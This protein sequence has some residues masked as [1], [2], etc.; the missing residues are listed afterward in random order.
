MKNF[1]KCSI[2]EEVDLKEY[3]NM[4]RKEF[5]EKFLK[6]REEN[7]DNIKVFS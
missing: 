7:E 3:L 2:G 1:R 6:F 4:L 5:K